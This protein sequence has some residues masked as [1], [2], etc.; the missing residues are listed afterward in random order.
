MDKTIDFSSLKSAI[1]ADK[2]IDLARKHNDSETLNETLRRKGD[3]YERRNNYVSS[4]IW[5]DTFAPTNLAIA[6]VLTLFHPKYGVTLLLPLLVGVRKT[7]KMTGSLP[8]V[9]HRWLMP[10]ASLN[11]AAEVS[12][13]KSMTT[14]PSE[15]AR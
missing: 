5:S 14:W 1:T 10:C 12:T 13:D 15:K 2:I 6:V 11:H 4:E 7:M 3:I 8:T 9:A